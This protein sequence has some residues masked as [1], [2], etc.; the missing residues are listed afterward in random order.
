[1]RRFARTFV[2]AVGA[3]GMLNGLSGPGSSLLSV[4]TAQAKESADSCI[5]F[6]R[7]EAEKGLDYGVDNSCER[8]LACTL[9]WTVSCEDNHGKVTSTKG[10]SSHFRLE[11]NGAHSVTASAAECKQGWNI[12]NVRWHCDE[13]K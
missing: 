7:T 1:M 4:R 8:K 9:S 2:Y 6:D 11:E 12:D 10:Y 3:F 5:R 13:A